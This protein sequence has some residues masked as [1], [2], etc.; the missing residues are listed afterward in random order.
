MSIS[1]RITWFSTVWL[2]VILLIVNSGIYFLFEQ[3]TARAELERVSSQAQAIAEAAGGET[4]QPA[5]LFAAYV[6]GEGMIRVIRE[7][8]SEAVTITKNPAMRGISRMYSVA[9]GTEQI[10]YQGD[11]IAMARFPVIWNDGTVVTLEYS[12]K[13]DTFESTLATLRLVLV[14]A[15]LLVLIPAFFAGRALSRL[16]LQP[17]QALMQTMEGIRKSGTFNRIEVSEESKDEL[18]QMGQ[19]FNRMIELLEC[20]Y[21]KQQQFVSDASHELRT[22][23]TVIESYANL[24]K[25][26]GMTN[27]ERLKEAVEAILEESKRMKGLTQQMLSLATGEQDRTVELRKLELSL[28]A[29]ETA[30]KLQQAYERDIHIGTDETYTILGD[31]AR[32][33]QLLFILLENG[34]KYSNDSLTVT[35]S[36]YNEFVQMEVSDQGIGISEKDLPHVFERFFRVDKARSRQTGGSGLGLAIA[37]TIVDVHGGQ[38]SVISKEQ[39]G[40]TF[41]VLLPMAIRKGGELDE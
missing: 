9:Q 11:R 24:L 30:R 15:S 41:T 29:Q 31:E 20:N 32:I 4:L 22:P 38:I 5:D 13:M 16:L 10:R 26:W 36:H 37:K 33:K 2:L 6:A 18:D 17:I 21:E 23:L 34:L 1:R 25:R 39:V 14:V 8:G 12:E 40:T 35:F 7:D 19:T 28:L 3:L 27:P